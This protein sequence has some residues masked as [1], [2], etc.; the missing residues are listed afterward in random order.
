[1]SETVERV[2]KSLESVIADA[3]SYWCSGSAIPCKP[4]CKCRDLTLEAARIAVEA[5]LPTK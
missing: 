3:M 1:M 4:E 2:A 5:I